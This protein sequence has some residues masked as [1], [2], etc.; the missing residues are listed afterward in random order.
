MT[1]LAYNSFLRHRTIAWRQRIAVE[2]ITIPIPNLPPA[3]DG[4]RIVQISDLHLYPFTR[5]DH[6]RTAVKMANQLAPDV[7]VLTGDYVSAQAEPIFELAPELDKL[8][9]RAGVFAILGNHDIWTGRHTV[10]QGFRETRIPLLVN[11]AVPIASFGSRLYLAGVDDCWSGRPDLDMA[12]ASVPGDAPVVLLAHEPDTADSFLARPQIALQL[13][14][15]THGG[16]VRFPRFGPLFLP[17]LG[18]K[19]IQGL[20]PIGSSWLYTNRGLGYGAVPLRL[21]C[22]PELTEVTLVRE[23][24]HGGAKSN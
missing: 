17:H 22:C 6:I 18:R 15:H 24:H 14:G 12:L 9:A 5:I 10:V 21:N 13:S 7:T 19:Y 2:R 11:Q 20:Y 8:N 23:Q 4:M 3:A 16:Q 1:S